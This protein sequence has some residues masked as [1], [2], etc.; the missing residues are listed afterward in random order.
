MFGS[1]PSFNQDIGG[2]NVRQVTDMYAMFYNASSFNQNI[3]FWCV[4]NFVSKPT[5]FSTF[6]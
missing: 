2:W 3:S 4:T 5:Y 6:E 1:A